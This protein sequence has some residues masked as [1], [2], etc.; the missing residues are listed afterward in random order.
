MT[1]ITGNKNTQQCRFGSI[2][3]VQTRSNEAFRR[4]R[5][6][7]AD[8]PVG[9]MGHYWEVPADEFSI[10][11]KTPGE[12]AHDTAFRVSN[13]G[14]AKRSTI[15]DD[16]IY[17][18]GGL[19][20]RDPRVKALCDEMQA[21]SNRDAKGKPV[22]HDKIPDPE[23]SGYNTPGQI[24]QITTKL[25]LKDRLLDLMTTLD[26]S[27]SEWVFGVAPASKSYTEALPRFLR[28]LEE[29]KTQSDFSTSNG[30]ETLFNGL[31]L[32]HKFTDTPARV[33]DEA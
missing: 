24:E 5:E 25:N 26:T 22:P 27:R 20:G 15:Y 10:H 18:G 1:P 7:G 33:V 8:L 23:L 28:V 13:G 31:Q 19:V 29:G 4:A 6:A 30:G 11:I 9:G 12:D 14:D 3:L 21:L 32:K 17:C 2:H 16:G